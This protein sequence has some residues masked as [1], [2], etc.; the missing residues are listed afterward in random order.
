MQEAL[1]DVV[2]ARQVDRATVAK[3]RH[4]AQTVVDGPAKLIQ[5]RV[6]MAGGNSDPAIGQKLRGGEFGI[7]FRRDGEE[8]G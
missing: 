1:E 5:A 6:A 4:H 8:L 3:V 7:V 2:V